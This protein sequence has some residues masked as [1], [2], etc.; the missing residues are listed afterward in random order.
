MNET[1]DP[2][3][4]EV[5]ASPLPP[6]QNARRPFRKAFWIVVAGVV[7]LLAWQAFDRLETSQSVAT[8]AGNGG[9]PPT[10]VRVATVSIEPLPIVIDALGAVTPLATVTVRSQISGKLMDVTFVEGQSVKT[11][12]QLAHVDDRPFQ[13]TLAQAQATLAKDTATLSQAQA[14]LVRYQALNRQDSISAQQV[15]DQ[16]FLVSQDKAAVASDQAQIDAAKLNITYASIVSPITGQL[17]LRLVD[18]GNYVTPADG[19]GIVVITQMD[20]ISVVFTTAEDNLPAITKRLTAGATLKVEVRDRG[21]TK[22]LATGELK[23]FDNEI[24]TSTGTL[25]LR[26]VFKNPEG[27]LFPNQFV[28][29]RLTVDTLTDKPVAPSAAVQIGSIGSFAYVVNDDSTVSVRTVKTG[30]SAGDKVAILSGLSAGERVVVDG[31]DRLRDGAKVSIAPDAS[32]TTASPASTRQR[33]QQGGQRGQR[34]KGREQ[35]DAAAPAT[36][37]SAA[38]TAQP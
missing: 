27:N 35:P 22:T 16:A 26:A 24:D 6:P 23:T 28:N 8:R 14:D 32:T 19:T 10:T 37:P 9:G 12:D 18:P 25:K 11:G 33:G 13:A 31:V 5:A 29:V 15:E 1:V 17:G 7:V 4:L 38:P 3:Q 30:P 36:V 2:S 34:Q 20:P 21:D